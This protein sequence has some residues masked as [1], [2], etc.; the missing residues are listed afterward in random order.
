MGLTRSALA[1]RRSRA[2]YRTDFKNG[3][4]TASSEGEYWFEK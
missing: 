2:N 4:P 1:V 3:T